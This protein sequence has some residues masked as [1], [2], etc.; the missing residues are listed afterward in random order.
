M[1]KKIVLLAAIALIGAVATSPKAAQAQ[2]LS[3]VQAEDRVVA[4]TQA[5]GKALVFNESMVWLNAGPLVPATKGIRLPS[6][7][8]E[9]EAED[10]DYLYYRSPQ[11]F[12]Y[13]L[14]QDGKVKDSRFMPGGVYMS[15]AAI[16]LVPAGV[17]LT[18]DG[19]HKTLIWKLGADFM[20]LEGTKWKK[21]Q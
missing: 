2:G 20:Q 11:P 10:A 19:T 15:K 6:G 21:A 7:R 1:L 8:Y 5:D 13:R 12:E 17:Y 16:T 18:N 14:F 4:T 3:P 9:L